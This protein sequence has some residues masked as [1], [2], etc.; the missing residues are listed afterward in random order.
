MQALRYTFKKARD[1]Y[2]VQ[3]HHSLVRDS[4]LVKADDEVLI[5]LSDDDQGREP[6]IRD[7]L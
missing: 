5:E 1:S 7:K 2:E 6:I 4:S 3:S